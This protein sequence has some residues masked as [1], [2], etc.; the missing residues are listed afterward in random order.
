LVA[1]PVD[2]YAIH[3][4]DL[5]P[6]R[7]REIAKRRPA[8]I[9]SLDAMNRNL[10]TVVVCPLTT[11]LHPRW[12]SRIEVVCAGRRAEIAV[13]QIRTIST[14]R[15]GR[16]IDALD[17]AVAARLRRLISEMYGEPA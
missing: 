2:R 17:A 11:K 7:G 9:V 8:V 14:E 16:K 1:R 13:D 12:R 4:A 15:L 3:I 5:D 10:D 6:T